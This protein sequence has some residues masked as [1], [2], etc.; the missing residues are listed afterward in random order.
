M[1]PMPVPPRRGEHRVPS[2]DTIGLF[3]IGSVGSLW[4]AESEEPN[5]PPRQSATR[6]LSP[7]TQRQFVEGL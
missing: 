3:G 7:M 4:R 6:S 1:I 2:G 5:Q